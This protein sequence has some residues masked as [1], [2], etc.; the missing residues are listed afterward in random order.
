MP[1]PVLSH[2][3]A[4]EFPELAETIHFL[5]MNDHHFKKILAQHDE[6]DRQITASEEG[7]AALDD[8]ALKEMKIKRLHFKEE[9]HQMALRHKK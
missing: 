7:L 6:V 3:L 4:I 8:A 9:L 2:V 5:K 1:N